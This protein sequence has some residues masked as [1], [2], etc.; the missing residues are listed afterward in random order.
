MINCKVAYRQ[1]ANP[2]VPAD[3]GAHGV[4]FTQ[5]QC[6]LF[7]SSKPCSRWEVGAYPLHLAAKRGRL[8]VMEA[9]S[10]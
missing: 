7:F 4:G 8:E 5:V 10:W 3:S 2:N 6:R 9:F 1:G